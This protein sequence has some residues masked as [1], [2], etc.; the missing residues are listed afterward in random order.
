MSKGLILKMKLI[1]FHAH[2]YPD[3]I[4]EKATESVEKFYDFDANNIGTKDVLLTESVKAGI[5]LTVILPVAI[6]PTGV[7]HI[8][9]FALE[10]Q[11]ENSSFLSFGTLH[12]EQTDLCE[13][14]QRIEKEGVHGIKIHPDT[15][16]FSIDDERMFPVYDYIQGKMP[17]IVHTGDPR[18][19]YSHPERLRRIMK[20]FPSLVCIA[21]H[22]GGWAMPDEGA[23]YL[24]DME[25]CFADMSSTFYLFPQEK[26]EK[27]IPL[28]G[29]DR[30]LFG[31]DF[32]LGS[33]SEEKENLLRL[34]ISDEAKEKIAYKNAERLLNIKI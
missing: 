9:D 8:N 7:S 34:N 11:K 15:Q 23:K 5:N 10:M 30:L 25:N 12:A 2:I 18:H 29:E 17:L 21:A 6:K 22:F 13:E 16:L 28:W 4:A 3:R 26:I 19:P 1:D 14:L 31:S 32:P 20:M 33:P 27:L 24:S